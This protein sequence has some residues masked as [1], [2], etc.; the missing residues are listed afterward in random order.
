ML[1]FEYDKEH[2]D[3][4]EDIVEN[5]KLV[6]AGNFDVCVLASSRRP[7]I[8]KNGIHI[9]IRPLDEDN[10]NL[11][12]LLSFIILGHEDWENG[13]IKIFSVCREKE[14]EKVK[15]EMDT[16]VESGRLPI[17]NNNIEILISEE[18][19]SRKSLINRHSSDAALTMIGFREEAINHDPSEIFEGHEEIGNVLF[20]NSREKKNLV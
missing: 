5:F 4:L 6:S 15:A 10:A 20:L 7:I 1:I 11:M 14:F 17:T 19:E 9:W 12:I 18:N 8:Y 3:E 2:P 13:N 16:L